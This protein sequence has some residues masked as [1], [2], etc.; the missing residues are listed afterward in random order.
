[1]LWLNLELDDFVIREQSIFIQFYAPYIGGIIRAALLDKSI[2]NLKTSKDQLLFNVIMNYFF[3]R[4][5]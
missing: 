1:M 2:Q 4:K 3:F 5:S